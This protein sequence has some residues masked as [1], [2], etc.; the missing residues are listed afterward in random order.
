MRHLSVIAVLA[1]L[2]LHAAVWKV[3]PGRT[4]TA[5][6]KVA[7]LV[8]DGDT[9]DIDA[10]TYAGEASV[11]SRHRLLLRGRGGYANLV[12]PATIPNQKAIWVLAGNAI[13]VDSIEFSQAKVPDR[14]GAG[15]RA[16]GTDLTVRRS[17]FHDNENGILGGKGHVRVEDSRFERNG[18]GDGLSHNLYIANCDTFTLVRSWSRLAKVG[19]EVKSRAKVN[20]IV[21]NW[22]GNEA[23]GNA[24]YEIDLPN[25][26]T[27]LV[28][29]NMI[30]QGP[31]TENSTMVSYGAEGL[32]SS[33]NVLVLSHNTLVNDRSAGHLRAR[34]LPGRRAWCA[35]ISSPVPGP[36]SREPWIPRATAPPPRRILSIA[37]ASTTAWRPGRAPSTRVAISARLRV[38]ACCP[39]SSR[40][41]G[42]VPWRARSRTLRTWEPGKWVPEHVRSGPLA[43]VALPRSCAWRRICG[44]LPGSIG[45]DGRRTGASSERVGAAG[46]SIA[47]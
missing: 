20:V 38:G 28:S 35:T 8:A 13:V 21:G 22:I 26:G 42:R 19:H 17:W 43:R 30:Q 16:E 44:R 25:G 10:G 36:G 7:A 5:P 15:I 4:H 3:G 18:Y 23:E 32:G 37:R 45:V 9:V 40:C 2:P 34:R 6:S 29:G 46:V 31:K 1:S 47:P 27:S 33:N 11:W 41:G 39:R 12:A 24:S 14:N